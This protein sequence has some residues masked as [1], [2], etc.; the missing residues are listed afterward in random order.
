MRVEMAV[1]L[2]LKRQRSFMRYS[3]ISSSRNSLPNAA[4]LPLDWNPN[5]VCINL[6][7]SATTSASFS[8]KIWSASW[9]R[10][11]TA[12][13]AA[14]HGILYSSNCYYTGFH[15]QTDRQTDGDTEGRRDGQRM[16]LLMTS[17]RI[18]LMP[19]LVSVLPFHRCYPCDGLAYSVIT[20][21]NSYMTRS[22]N[23]W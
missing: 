22:Q 12:V 23:W 4:L 5:H 8:V 9:H 19:R 7:S 6:L 20:D 3:H 15:E 18:N 2:L 16:L 17:H 11:R 21:E 14:D 10:G 13:V 1:L